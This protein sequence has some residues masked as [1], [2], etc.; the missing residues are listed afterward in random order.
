MKNVPHW[1]WLILIYFI[2]VAIPVYAVHA[3]LKKKLLQNKT[4]S[5]LLLYFIAVIATAF[6][7]NFG[8]M[9][10]YYQFMFHK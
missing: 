6:I 8:V 1:Q 4:A 3:Y 7:M 2:A 9:W 10:A 5:N